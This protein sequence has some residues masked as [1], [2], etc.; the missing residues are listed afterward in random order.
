MDEEQTP[1][2]PELGQGVVAC[3]NG[4]HSLLTVETDPDVGS[5][6]HRH[7][8]SPVPDRQSDLVETFANQEHHLCLLDG[9]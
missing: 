1:Q 2:H 6:Y 9:E 8:V 4:S 5:L 7:V 3:L